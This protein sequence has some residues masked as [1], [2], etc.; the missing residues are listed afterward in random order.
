MPIAEIQLPDGRIA[1]IEVPK[2]AT[3]EQIMSYVQS[4]PS[5]FEPQIGRLEAAG[6]TTLQGS[7]FGLSDELSAGIAA[8]GAKGLTLGGEA[9]GI[10]SLPSSESLSDYY[11]TALEEQRLK[12]RQAESAY[13][14][15]SLATGL[16]GGLLSGGALLKGANLLKPT[17]SAGAKG[18]AI[19]TGLE[20]I[21]KN[22]DLSKLPGELGVNVPLGAVT[23]GV[24]Q[25]AIPSATALTGKAVKKG[26]ELTGLKTSTPKAEAYLAKN[27]S[28][29]QAK[30]GLETLESASSPQMTGVDLDNP[31]IRNS[32]ITAIEKY[33]QSKQIAADFT[34]GRK[35]Q[36]LTRIQN[37]LSKD[38]SPVENAFKSIDD[39]QNARKIT[40]D[41]FRVKAYEEGSYIPTKEE[42]ELANIKIPEYFK[43][44]TLPDSN[45]YAQALKVQQSNIPVN[46]KSTES[47]EIGSLYSKI[48]E[49]PV[50]S[51]YFSSIRKNLDLENIPEN[52]SQFLH[53]VR[54]S[55]TQDIT[56]LESGISRAQSTGE[57]IVS[58]SKSDLNSLKNSKNLLNKLLYKISPSL[59][60]HDEIYAESGRLENAIIQGQ[61]FAKKNPYEIRKELKDLSQAEKEAYRIGVRQSMQ[62]TIEKAVKESGTSKPAEALINKQYSKSQIKAIFGDE[63]KATNFVKKL[64]EEIKFNETQKALGLDK[65][66]ID[67]ASP[68]ELMQLIGEGARAGGTGYLGGLYL[69]GTTFAEKVLV[70]RYR[71]L[72]EKTAKD[73]VNILTD[74][75]KSKQI[76]KK[77]ANYKDST[78]KQL[79]ND[80]INS[81]SPTLSSDISVE[82]GKNINKKQK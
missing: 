33:P 64:S 31:E 47:K 22:E 27:I 42:V 41:P 9:L 43:G 57:K 5:L 73:L 11:K 20:T 67:Q 69:K 23:G 65:I 78:Q 34:A 6:R 55:I 62:D 16:G 36:A 13:P 59:K 32:L 68:K 60:R 40:A 10:E 30:A 79:A 74:Q 21:G 28:P 51:Q 50:I 7:T 14:K 18:G 29:E 37:S 24:L 70:K 58:G 72:N 81:L 25:K 38:I 76:L 3:Q 26:L 17:F 35:E 46:L 75:E 54:K 63:V 1:E 19:L 12:L 44:I 52:S 49:D 48:K 53:E 80:I 77:I 45:K 66:K 4:N 8:L 15:Q 2:G 71:G 82:V 39:L 61:D 56:Q